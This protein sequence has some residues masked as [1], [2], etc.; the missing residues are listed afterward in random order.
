[1][2]LKAKRT[3]VTQKSRITNNLA[4]VVADPNQSRTT[5]ATFYTKHWGEDFVPHKTVSKAQGIPPTSN[6]AISSYRSSVA[7]GYENLTSARQGLAKAYRDNDSIGMEDLPKIF[8][9][10]TFSLSSPTAFNKLFTAPAVGTSDPLTDTD[11]PPKSPSATQHLTCVGKLPGEFRDR[12]RLGSVL[13][14]YHDRI[15]AVLSSKLRQKH[16]T[17]WQTIETDQDLDSALAEA[18]TELGEI[19]SGLQRMQLSAVDWRMQIL[20]ACKKLEA[21]VILREKLMDIDL[22]RNTTMFVQQ[23]LKNSDY[24]LGLQCIETSHGLLREGI[25][26]MAAFR[27]ADNQLIETRKMVNKLVYDAFGTSFDREFAKPLEDWETHFNSLLEG[28][29]PRLITALIQLQDYRFLGYLKT[30]IHDATTNLMRQCVKS[31]LVLL[32]KAAD[33]EQNLKQLVERLSLEEWN[34]ILTSSLITMGN[35]YKK[36]QKLMLIL[37]DLSGCGTKPQPQVADEQVAGT[38]AGTDLQFIYDLHKKI[39]LDVTPLFKCALWAE[40]TKSEIQH[41]EDLPCAIYALRDY[42]N[43]CLQTRLG[44][45]L[46]HRK[47]AYSGLKID[48]M[49]EISSNW[50]V[51]QK[52]GREY[53][54]EHRTGEEIMTTVELCARTIANQFANEFIKSRSEEL[55]KVLDDEGWHPVRLSPTEAEQFKKL[56][57]SGFEYWLVN[58]TVKDPVFDP[59]TFDEACSEQFLQDEELKVVGATAH[60]VQTLV[61]A[62]TI[63]YF[64]LTKLIELLKLFNS[65]SCQ[66]I[67]G[68][69]AL[70]MGKLT[71]ISVRN[72]AACARSLEQIMVILPSFCR[73]IL[74]ET[75]DL[76]QQEKDEFLAQ[77]ELIVLDYCHHYRQIK[78]KLV[79]WEPTIT[80]ANGTSTNFLTITRNFVKFCDGI[81][82]ML[83][84][85]Q[86]QALIRHIHMQFRAQLTGRLAE[87]SI[88]PKNALAWGMASRDYAAYMT[89][90]QDLL[91]KVDCK[92]ADI[93]KESLTE[94]FLHL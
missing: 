15:D 27:E 63:G 19:R 36:I 83:T 93:P 31:Q 44:R 92:E 12:E 21:K 61:G 79:E 81:G 25:A 78:T 57:G 53:L 46:D 84:R 45:L 80:Q 77:F 14:H 47:G 26:D 42:A 54:K 4:S 34:L 50:L 16:N 70:L 85:Y 69:G 60:L 66:L 87:L 56:Y 20:N 9:S 51:V 11:R 1:M 37:F 23:C 52:F 5:T 29:L 22:L 3:K 41:E 58:E 13:D 2:F 68:A 17:I 82:T 6:A 62:S 39:G 74:G 38:V 75:H 67:L 49:N 88:S 30:S 71:S 7:Q 59:V 48:S 94:M 24:L 72:L 89:N 64:A 35:H 73:N 40:T 18:L 86:S 28:D 32:N 90:Y 8:A 33:A 10:P 65:R 43:C 91:R 76:S 55:S